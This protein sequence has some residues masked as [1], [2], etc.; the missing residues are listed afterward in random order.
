MGSVILNMNKCIC[1]I[2]YR[3][4]SVLKNGKINTHGYKYRIIHRQWNG[5]FEIKKTFR[6]KIKNPCSG[7]GMEAKDIIE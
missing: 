4:I 6:I 5:L 1:Q 7:S 3:E 2:C